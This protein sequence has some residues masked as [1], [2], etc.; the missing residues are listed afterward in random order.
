MKGGEWGGW[1]GRGQSLT[2][3]RRMPRTGKRA[4]V[5][6]LFLALVPGA[7]AMAILSTHAGIPSGDVGIFRIKRW[8]AHFQRVHAAP[9]VVKLL[10]YSSLIQQTLRKDPQVPARCSVQ[11]RPYCYSV[12]AGW[13]LR[14]LIETPMPSTVVWTCWEMYHHFQEPSTAP[15]PWVCTATSW[16]QMQTSSSLHP[17]DAAAFLSG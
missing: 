17:T 12:K 11:G 3:A 10:E 4:L 2:L 9:G 6:N 5:H 13:R 7:W 15:G 16:S 14:F 8:D 1:W